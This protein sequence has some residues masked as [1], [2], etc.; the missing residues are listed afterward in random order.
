MPRPGLPPLARAAPGE[1]SHSNPRQGEVL[2]TIAELRQRAALCPTDS[3][4]ARSHHDAV[5]ADA[6]TGAPAT[7]H[8]QHLLRTRR[9][10]PGLGWCGE[11]LC[12]STLVV[13]DVGLESEA[14]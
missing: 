10:W 1:A 13:V 12:M 8:G 2:V 3:A 6:A 5:R 11:C 14:A 4:A 7:E 9:E